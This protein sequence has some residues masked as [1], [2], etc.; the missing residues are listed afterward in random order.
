MAVALPIPLVEPVTRAVLPLRSVMRCVVLSLRMGVATHSGRS[1][2]GC[3]TQNPA[4][5]GA[6]STRRVT[7]RG[8]PPR[9]H[10]PGHELLSGSPEPVA[11]TG[12]PRLGSSECPF[13]KPTVLQTAPLMQPQGMNDRAF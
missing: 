13:E 4:S 7:G 5:I 12:K 9:E 2:L 10:A 3:Q 11:Y 8:S 6:W 1:A